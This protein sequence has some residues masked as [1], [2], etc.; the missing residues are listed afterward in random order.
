M[1]R[2][3]LQFAFSRAR[4][5]V[6]VLTLA[7]IS[8]AA[9]AEVGD[10]FTYIDLRYRIL[11]E[12]DLTVSLIGKSGT[13]SSLSGEMEFRPAVTRNGKTYSVTEIADNAGSNVTL[14]FTNYPPSEYKLKY[15]GN[16]VLRGGKTDFTKLP[17]TVE[18]L[19]NASF[20]NRTDITTLDIPYN[21]KFIGSYCFYGCSNLTTLKTNYGLVAIGGDAFNSCS[22]LSSVI[23]T[24]SLRYLGLGSF[25]AC[26]ALPSID[27]PE[28]LEIIEAQAFNYCNQMTQI[29]IPSTVTKIG[30]L[31]FRN[32]TK[33]NTVVFKPTTEPEFL[34]WIGYPGVGNVNSDPQTVTLEKLFDNAWNNQTL[35]VPSRTTY[36]FGTEIVTFNENEY[37]YTGKKIIPTYTNNTPWNITENDFN[38]LNYTHG[39]WDRQVKLWFPEFGYVTI[40]YHYTVNRAPLSVKV[41]DVTQEYGDYVLSSSFSSTIEGFVANENE[42]YINNYIS[43]E[44]D[45]PT[46]KANAGQYPITASLSDKSNYFFEE[47]IPGT[48][49]I[50]KAPVT[51]MPSDIVM[52]YGEPMP[53][54]KVNYAFKGTCTTAESL[55]ITLTKPF[56]VTT[57]A[58]QSANAGAYP[59]TISGGECQNYEFT[60]YDPAQVIINKAIANVKAT[61]IS[62]V[63]GEENPEINFDFSGLKLDQT[64]V[65]MTSPFVISELPSVQS[66]AATY[67]L[68]LT[69]GE[70]LNYT[71]QYQPSSI[72]VTKA[73]LTVAVSNST[74]EYG[75]KNPE[76][77]IV[78]TGLKEWDE[79]PEFNIAPTIACEADERSSV[80]VY[81]ITFSG[82]ESPKYEITE[83]TPGNLTITKAPL[84]LKAADATRLYGDVNPT[85]EME[86][87]GLKPCDAEYVGTPAIWSTL[88]EVSCN[89][90]VMSNCGE[91]SI[92]IAGG[93]ANNYE[94]TDRLSGILTIEKRDLLA[95]PADTSRLYGEENPD[96]EIIYDGF[97]YF[98]NPK[99]LIKEPTVITEANAE[100]APGNYALTLQGGE[101]NNYNLIYSEGNMTIGKVSLAFSKS[102]YQATY[103]GEAHWPEFD[104]NGYFNEE[105][106]RN[107]LK[108]SYKDN[109][110]GQYLY[111]DVPEIKNAG[112]Y[113]I[114]LLTEDNPYYDGHGFADFIIEKAASNLTVNVDLSNL[115]VED[116]A[117]VEWSCDDPSAVLSISGTDALRLDTYEENGETHYKVIALKSGEG[118][119]N[120]IVTSSNNYLGD[121]IPVNYKVKENSGIDDIMAEGINL[122][123]EGNRIIVKGKPVNMRLRVFDISG[124]VIYSGTESEVEVAER[125]IY[126][127]VL[128]NSSCKIKM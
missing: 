119:V 41:N 60:Q 58:S 66:P 80:G 120:F 30:E 77:D 7:L 12:A 75:D 1:T 68:T 10:E 48:L 44:C 28:G 78:Y 45:A 47:I 74:R 26:T 122:Y 27:L 34:D 23:L 8:I 31:V 65:E 106:T 95:K 71:F 73:P 2:Q 102:I 103:D 14:K 100:S 107:L 36:S 94:I 18:Y 116:E 70:S 17:N 63:Y 20:E 57:D 39:T 67:P 42:S 15:I 118:T 51:V 55:G 115:T 111:V 56:V 16:Q 128:G 91:Y 89:A 5:I 35:Y 72:T 9:H 98:D 124:R 88:A 123:T 25:Q 83:V 82:G 99:S 112:D 50:T 33:L 4:V 113:R 46:V 54:V 6:S 38:S 96:F 125:A 61:P 110:T 81:P 59:L 84:K 52:T 13:Y 85:F 32:C 126:I 121:E 79:T 127:V 86:Y 87:V 117:V 69:G 22:K 37:T 21:I 11:S 109:S 101:S 53:E 64:S 24:G 49:T 93:E 19:G 29:V 108:I 76:W 104:A 62:R 3:L 97:T 43:Y 92:V 114:E 90:N 40:P 105:Q